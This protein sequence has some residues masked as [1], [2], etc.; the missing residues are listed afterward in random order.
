MNIMN[1]SIKLCDSL[2]DE[3]E[4]LFQQYL[5]KETDHNN[6]AANIEKDT[7]CDNESK[8]NENNNTNIDFT[9]SN[10]LLIKLKT[11]NRS[12]YLSL[13]QTRNRIDMKKTEIDRKKLDFE[14]LLYEIQYWEREIC[15]TK[16]IRTTHL[17]K[18]TKDMIANKKALT[19][20][21]NNNQTAT[22]DSNKNSLTHY[23]G[24]KDI[25][26]QYQQYQNEIEAIR[27]DREQLKARLVAKQSNNYKLI[28]KKNNK[29]KFLEDLPNQ[30][31]SI[32][33][34]AQSLQTIMSSAQD[35]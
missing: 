29:R 7:S 6:V 25:K 16:K 33:D 32:K 30:M 11:C 14:N 1:D 24:L 23:D 17:E 26:L 9:T 20:S 21:N 4:K 27:I 10:A 18:L 31:S 5:N 3:S 13:D 2:L 22:T 8:N 15:N 19:L 12:N 28:E 34:V 35:K